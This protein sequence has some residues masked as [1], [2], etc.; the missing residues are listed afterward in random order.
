VLALIVVR[1]AVSVDLEVLLAERVLTVLAFEGQKVDEK[2]S[3]VGA[4]LS[5]AEKRGVAFGSG[6]GRGERHLNDSG[7]GKMELRERRDL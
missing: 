2:T 6:G 7:C 3:G 4:L 5:D 1:T